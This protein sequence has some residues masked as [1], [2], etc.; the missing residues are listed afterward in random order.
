M[1][2]LARILF[3]ALLLGAAAAATAGAATAA[4]PRI[5]VLASHEGAPYRDALRGFQ[6]ALEQ[7][8]LG[9]ASIDVRTFQ[10][11]SAKARQA[12]QQVRREGTT[13]LVTLGAV[14]TQAALAEGSEIPLV[15]GMILSA[16]TL[17]RSGNATGVVLDLPAEVQLEWM[18]RIVPES[19][20]VGVLYN[21]R[22]NRQ[23][24]EAA[25]RA[26]RARGLRL[27]AREVETPEALP[28][29]LNSLAKR[30]DVLWG[31]VDPIVL[32]PETAQAVLLFSFRNRIPFVGLSAAWVKAGATY[33]LDW[34]YEDVGRQCAELTLKILKGARAGAIAPVFPRKLTY[35]LNLK[36]VRHMKLEISESLVHGAAQVFE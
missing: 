4:R 11:D 30:V 1:G 6:Q 24:V 28:E 33:A 5:V 8:G 29:A 13:V 27:V 16:D 18:Q 10:G 3:A 31:I 20:A 12:V 14:T 25:E 23:R 7:G 35:S 19:K 17:Q 34:D 32:S 26:A 21:P 2:R 15:A 9:D 36:A 22:E